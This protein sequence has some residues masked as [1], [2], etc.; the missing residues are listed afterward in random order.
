MLCQRTSSA[1]GRAALHSARVPRSFVSHGVT[2]GGALQEPNK[3]V[4]PD[5]AVAFGAAV[6]GGILSGEASLASLLSPACALLC[7]A[8]SANKADRWG[9]RGR[10]AMGQCCWA[11]GAAAG[12][13]GSKRALSGPCATAFY[14][15]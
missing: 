2:S 4:N 11:R 7:A 3:G 13:G 8:A 1:L 12:Y 9:Q 15:V 6:Q 10:R 14:R 5:E